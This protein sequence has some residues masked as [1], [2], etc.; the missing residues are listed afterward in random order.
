MRVCLD[1]VPAGKNLDPGYRD[2]FLWTAKRMETGVAQFHTVLIFRLGPKAP[3]TLA[4]GENCVCRLLPNVDF[5]VNLELDHGMPPNGT[6]A[7]TLPK[8]GIV[9]Y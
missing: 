2:G 9:S 6:G 1:C 7:R 3:V 5:W 4:A 8:L